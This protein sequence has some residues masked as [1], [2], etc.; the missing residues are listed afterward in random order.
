M[1]APC[2][3]GDR[4]RYPLS[5]FVDCVAP[6]PTCKLVRFIPYRGAE[7]AGQLN[8]SKRKKNVPCL[9]NFFKKK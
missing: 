3:L 2:G 6:Y 1:E 9:F 5:P 7:L 8:T 4:T